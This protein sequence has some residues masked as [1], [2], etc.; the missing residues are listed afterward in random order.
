MEGPTGSTH[1]RP[2]VR[3]PVVEASASTTVTWA[4]RPRQVAATSDPMN[5][6]PDD[7]EAGAGPR[8]SR[9]EGRCESSRV[10]RV[11]TP[12][13]A[14]GARQ[15]AGVGAGGE[16]EPVEADRGSVVEL[17]GVAVDV[18]GWRR[19]AQAEV[20]AEGGDLLGRSQLHAVEP[21][22]SG[23]EL[24]G[25]RG[26]VVGEVGLGTDQDDGTGVPL[27][28]QCLGGPEAGQGGAD[29]GDGGTSGPVAPY[30]ASG[31]SRHAEHRHPLL[32]VPGTKD[33]VA[34]AG[35]AQAGRRLGRV[36]VPGVQDGVVS[37]ARQA[38][39]ERLVHLLGV[40]AGKVGAAAAVE[41]QGVSRHQPAVDEEAL[42]SRR[43]TGSV[44]QLDPDVADRDDVA[45]GVVRRARRRRL[46]WPAPPTGPRLAGRARG[47]GPTPGGSVIPSIRYPIRSPPTWSGWKCVARTPTQ[48]MS[49]AARMSRSP[50]TS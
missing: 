24:L 5:P 26:A 7:D 8:D 3:G 35:I 43:V 10:R 30:G 25:E 29:D 1:L 17:E 39:G 32:D 6:A 31:S 34:L 2:R 44:D 36:A 48:R 15:R 16:H 11:C 14:G 37:E 45:A 9:P 47:P 22:G 41:E 12:G 23:Q 4:P 21:P 13:N 38:G 18:E 33:V 50:P 40:A 28:A 46:R 19:V 27:G 42:A 20:E 49:S